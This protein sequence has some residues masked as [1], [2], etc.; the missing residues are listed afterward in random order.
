[1]EQC[2]FKLYYLSRCSQRVVSSSSS[3]ELNSISTNWSSTLSPSWLSARD[4]LVIVGSRSPQRYSEVLLFVCSG[5]QPQ[6][7]LG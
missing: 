1:M 2:T 4:V 6:V 7:V 5:Y 3:I